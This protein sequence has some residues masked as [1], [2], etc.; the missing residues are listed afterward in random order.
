MLETGEW[1][2]LDVRT[3]QEQEQVGV[4]DMPEYGPGLVTVTSH[5]PGPRGMAFDKEDWIEKVRKEFP[6]K[7][8]KMVVGCA[9]GV[10]SKAAASVLEADGYTEVSE[11]DDGYNGWRSRGLPVKVP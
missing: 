3:T 2:Y 6:D 5:V 4:V 11:L 1:A 10:R 8:Q 7:Q 9:A